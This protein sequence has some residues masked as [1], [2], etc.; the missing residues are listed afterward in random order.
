MPLTRRYASP[1]AAATIVLLA[2]G[3][4]AGGPEEELERAGAGATTAALAPADTPVVAAVADSALLDSAASTPASAPDS[5]QVPMP[6][7]RPL[8]PRVE[9]RVEPTPAQPA[10]AP[11]KPATVSKSPPRKAQA[12]APAPKPAETARV[13]AGQ[14]TAAR[15]SV[16]PAA[17]EPTPAAPPPASPP[18][19]LMPR[20]PLPFA[21]GERLEYDVRYGP[22]R[23]GRAVLELT[24]VEQLRGR[25]VFHALF[26]LRGGNA[27]I[28]VNDSYQSWFDTLS[29]A[30]LRYV[31]DIDQGPYERDRHWDIFPE[32][33][34]LQERGKQE[35]PSVALP[36]D[37]ASFI[38]FV[39]TLDLEPG[40]LY[41]FNRYFRPDRNPVKVHVLR[42]ERIKVPAGT[43]DAIVVRPIIKSKGI[44]GED[45][46]A[47]VWF[48]D[49]ATRRVLQIK[50]KLGVGTVSMQLR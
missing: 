8:E 24:P 43:F 36:L 28:R 37:D 5:V 45:G 25:P 9:P 26:T 47:E 40:R 14:T 30:S 2:L 39:R 31:Q 44:F 50:S 49:D 15:Q 12:V 34:V 29:L 19:S 38:Y 33:Q 42:R 4:C 13:A 11:S 27:L 17:R 22:F 18:P 6:V 41:E 23:V 3:A 20:R 32:R 7:S 46:H 35:E 48:A 16:T 10:P 1:V 21:A